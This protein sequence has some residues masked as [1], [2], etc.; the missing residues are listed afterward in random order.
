LSAANSVSAE[1]PPGPPAQAENRI[2]TPLLK[3]AVMTPTLRL[4][5][6]QRGE[7]LLKPSTPSATSQGMDPPASAAPV[8]NNAELLNNL[9]NAL[10]TP[11]PAD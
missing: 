2:L 4:S 1:R 6:F 10:L 9:S 5:A 7:R 11:E 8:G 3:L